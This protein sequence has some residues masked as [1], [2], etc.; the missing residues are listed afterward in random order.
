MSIMS[1]TASAGVSASDADPVYQTSVYLNVGDEL[2]PTGISVNVLSIPAS[3]FALGVEP[4]QVQNALTGEGGSAIG[5]TVVHQKRFLGDT[6]PMEALAWT[7]T[8]TAVR[9][10]G[11]F[12]SGPCAGRAQRVRR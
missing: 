4:W 8:A 7:A 9:A 10:L 12:R 5:P 11:R 6:G 1:R 3:R 2:R